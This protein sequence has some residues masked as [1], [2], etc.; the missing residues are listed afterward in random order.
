MATS[1]RRAPKRPRNANIAARDVP[2][3]TWANKPIACNTSFDVDPTAWS[4]RQLEN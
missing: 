2:T 3:D 4:V 1:S